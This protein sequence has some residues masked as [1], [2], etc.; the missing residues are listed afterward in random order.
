MSQRSGWGVAIASACSAELILIVVITVAGLASLFAPDH[1]DLIALVA[2]F[3]AAIALIL[4]RRW[5]KQSA[6]C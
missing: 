6:C 2:A 5:T 4:Q 3:L 1:I